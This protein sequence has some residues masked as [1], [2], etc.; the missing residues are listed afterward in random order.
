VK[1]FKGSTGGRSHPLRC[2]PV[3]LLVDKSGSMDL[4]IDLGKRIGALISAVCTEALYVYA[5]DTMA[6][7]VERAGG[8]LADWERAFAGI[9][10]GGTTSCGVGVEMLRRKKQRVEQII[11][12]T[13][14]EENEPPRF[15]ESLQRYRQEVQP[16]AAVCIVRTPDASTRLEDQCRAA[17]IKV[18]TF[19]FT[20]DYYSLPNLVPLLAPPTELDLLMEILEYPLPER[21]PG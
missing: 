5:F 12:I 16:D 9:T 21:K 15:V 7:P 14:E 6:Y 2:R 20:G 19:Q 1:Q 11:V 10:A 17:G 13:D 4:A 3:A 18:Q 8:T